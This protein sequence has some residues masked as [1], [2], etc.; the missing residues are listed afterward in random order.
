MSA[1]T[2]RVRGLAPWQPPRATF[3]LLDKVRSVLREYAQDLSLTVRQIFYRP[4]GAHGYDKSELAY[5]RLGEH[6]SC[7]RRAALIPWRTRHERRRS[8]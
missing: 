4:V 2:T 1:V 3:A 6:L 7:A 8:S 5:S